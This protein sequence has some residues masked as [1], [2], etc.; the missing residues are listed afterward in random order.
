LVNIVRDFSGLKDTGWPHHH[1]VADWDIQAH[2][3]ASIHLEL[4]VDKELDKRLAGYM[5]GS[6]SRVGLVDSL[7]MPAV[8][9]VEEFGFQMIEGA[10]IVSCCIHNLVSCKAMPATQLWEM[11]R[12]SS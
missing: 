1:T 12:D 3:A 2:A 6:P 4:L 5:M 7:H 11:E 9:Q 8:P 10:E